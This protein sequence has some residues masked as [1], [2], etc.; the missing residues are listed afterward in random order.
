MIP[1]GLKNA[2]FI[3]QRMVTRM[4]EAQIER[5]V[6][7]YIDDMVVKSKQA[8]K[9]LKDLKDAFLGAEET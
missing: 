4:F 7:G 1:F 5:N 2:G 9:Q 3:Y 6:E 8:L